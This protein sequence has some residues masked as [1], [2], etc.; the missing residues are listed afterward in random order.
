[1]WAERYDRDLQDI[2]AVQSDVTQK[3]V[4]A[5]A[6]KLMARER[7]WLRHASVSDLEAYDLRADA[8]YQP[9]PKEPPIIAR[10]KMYER[11]IELDP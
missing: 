9:I 4:D 2:F 3:V 10:Q 7:T 6:V 11:A 8:A 5:L 1:V